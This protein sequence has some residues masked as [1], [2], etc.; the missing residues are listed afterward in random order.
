MNRKILYALIFVAFVISIAIILKRSGYGSYLEPML[1]MIS[2]DP[3]VGGSNTVRGSADTCKE[4]C[5][6]TTGCKGFVYTPDAS[7]I[8]KSSFDN[9]SQKK[10][11]SIYK[12]A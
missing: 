5:D 3:N 6:K 12:K 7:C 9:V 11:Y 2:D 8:F 1:G 4:L 10:G